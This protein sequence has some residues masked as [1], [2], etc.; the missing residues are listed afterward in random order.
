MVLL[1]VTILAQFFGG[2]LPLVYKIFIVGSKFQE[3]FYNLFQDEE[4]NILDNVYQASILINIMFTVLGIPFDILFFHLSKKMYL[5]LNYFKLMVVSIGSST[6]IKSSKV[7]RKR[8]PDL[9]FQCITVSPGQSITA[10]GRHI[11]LFQN[12]RRL[13]RQDI[14]RISQTESITNIMSN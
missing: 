14:H 11:Q 3:S 13:I 10:A 7:Y 5:N 12:P 4:G 1:T 8:L 2:I 6:K 9:P